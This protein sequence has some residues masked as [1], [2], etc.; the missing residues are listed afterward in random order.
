MTRRAHLTGLSLLTAIGFTLIHTIVQ[1]GQ[2]PEA[3][4]PK[5]AIEEVMQGAHVAPEGQQ[6]LL[7]RVA[8]GRASDEEK[9][10]LLD[11]YISLAENE[12]PRGELTAFQEKTRPIIIAAAKVVVGREGAGAELR[13][14]VN[15]AG[16][17]RDHKPPTQ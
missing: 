16:C 2:D 12:P 17:H 7:A 5:H 13:R 14:A 11:F 9:Q 4:K 3:A 6:S 1:A 15:C 8:A 10:Q